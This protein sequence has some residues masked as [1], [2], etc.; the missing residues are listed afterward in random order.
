VKAHLLV[1]DVSVDRDQVIAAVDGIK[2]IENWYAFFTNT[3][4]LASTLDA[5]GLSKKIRERLPETKFIL[6][7]VEPSEKGG[8]L[9]KSVWSFLNRPVRANAEAA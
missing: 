3:M 1:F 2:E 4:C 5:K 9:P 8:W 6:T 7:T